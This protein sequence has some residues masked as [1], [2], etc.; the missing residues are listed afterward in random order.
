MSPYCVDS[1]YQYPNI[2]T[3]SCFCWISHTFWSLWRSL[4]FIWTCCFSLIVTSWISSPN[5]S[6]FI[7]YNYGSP[8][9]WQNFLVMNGC[10]CPSYRQSKF[11]VGCWQLLWTRNNLVTWF[12]FRWYLT[13]H[14]STSTFR[15]HIMNFLIL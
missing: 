12:L 6:E 2:W 1:S 4:S 9:F 11:V 14:C 13:V 15:K 8:S 5:C 7:S 3:I 10:L